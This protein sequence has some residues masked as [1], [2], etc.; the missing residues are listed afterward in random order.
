LS[1]MRFPAAV[2]LFLALFAV[3]RAEPVHFKDCGERQARPRFPHGR[4]SPPGVMRRDPRVGLG[5]FLGP[6]A[7]GAGLGEKVPAHL[8]APDLAQ[9][10]R[11]PCN[12]CFWGACAFIP[13]VGLLLKFSKVCR[14]AMKTGM[15]VQSVIPALGRQRQ[16]D[17]KFKGGLN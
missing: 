11:F 2:F 12:A 10:C 15:V 17:P 7:E 5:G 8:V 16:K 3:A 1:A 6:R 13:E 9:L 4:R 14:A